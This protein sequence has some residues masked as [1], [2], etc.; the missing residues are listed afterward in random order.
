MKIKLTH[1]I[2][3]LSLLFAFLQ[4]AYSSN[5]NTEYKCKEYNNEDIAQHY[6][7]WEEQGFVIGHINVVAENIFPPHEFTSTPRLYRWA[8][9]LHSK[10]K[11]RVIRQQ[12][13]IEEGDQYTQSRIEESERILRLKNYLYSAKIQVTSV[14]GNRVNLSVTTRDLWTLFPDLD[15]QRSGGDNSTRVGF[16]DSNFLGLGKQLVIVRKSDEIRSGTSFIYNDPN[17]LGSRNTLALGF[18]DN[19]DGE[20]HFI[21]L[22]RPFYSLDT[23]WSTGLSHFANDRTDSLY[24]RSRSTQEFQHDESGFTVFSGFS[25]RRKNEFIQ[26]WLVGFTERENVFFETNNTRVESVFP[27]NRKFS[28]PW[29]GWRLIEDQF[30]VEENF[31]FTGISEDINLGLDVFLRLGYSSESFGADNE[32]LL[33]ESRASKTTRLKGKRFLTLSTSIS[34][35][36]TGDGLKNTIANIQTQY[37]QRIFEQQQLYLA[38]AYSHTKNLFSDQQLLLGGDNGLRGYPSRYQ[39]GDRRYLISAEH[40]FYLNREIWRLFRLG[41]AVFADIGR[42]WFPNIDNGI[43]GDT[44]YDAGFGLRIS[45]TRAGKNVVLHLDFAFPL[46]AEDDD[47]DDFQIIFEAKSRF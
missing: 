11:P 45:P 13:L 40:R 8:N 21:N 37:R 15:Y 43:G 35:I 4:Q 14:C 9:T 22:R 6:R 18:T 20:S 26:R 23:R 30:S 24:F 27:E 12:L 16:R 44:L 10:T 47:V 42:A 1:V 32:G 41:T 25:P 2:S 39:A 38:L 28:Y 34:G 3:F 7:M 17:V 5:D 29:V 36:E 33:F 46:N 19:D 31:R